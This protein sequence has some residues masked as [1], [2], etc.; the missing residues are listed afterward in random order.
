[1]S[2]NDAR[3]AGCI[4]LLVSFRDFPELH[5]GRLFRPVRIPAGQLV[6]T[7]VC[8]EI[9]NLAK[10]DF[11][12]IDKRAVVKMYIVVNHKHQGFIPVY[13]PCYYKNHLH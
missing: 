1:M 12:K 4:W 11:N 7:R 6:Y 5:T 10:M 3:P 2:L 13:S 9:I 8:W